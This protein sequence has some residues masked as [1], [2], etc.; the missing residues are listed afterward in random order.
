MAQAILEVAP[1]SPA[2]VVIETPQQYPGSPAPRSQVQALEG[3]AGAIAAVFAPRGAAIVQ[4]LP[5]QWKGQLPKAVAWR[6]ILGRLAA[7]EV[8]V[9]PALIDALAQPASKW[10]HA[11]DA[12]GIG[13]HYL[14]RFGRL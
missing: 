6:R 12:V 10:G 4:Y 13:L 9:A 5:K 7:T 2:V 3:V 14:G 1:L 11:V 8:A